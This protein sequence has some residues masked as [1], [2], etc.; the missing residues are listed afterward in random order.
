MKMGWSFK[1]FFWIITSCILFACSHTDDRLD[2]R[3]QPSPTPTTASSGVPAAEIPVTF[4][5]FGK[6]TEDGDYVHA[7]KV[8]NTGKGVL[9]LKKVLPG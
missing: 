9:E 4:H 2:S 7:F 1:Q 8:K 6:L 5:D 3:T